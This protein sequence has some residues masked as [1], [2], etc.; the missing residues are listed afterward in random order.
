MERVV[1]IGSSQV[2]MRASALIPRL[3]RYTFG[4]DM[5]ADMNILQKDAAEVVTAQSKGE[6]ANFSLKDLTVF[7][8]VSYIMAMHATELN[9]NEWPT[10]D[11]WLDSFDG[12]MSIYESLPQVLELWALNQKTTSTPR[13]K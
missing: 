4:S 7:E 1:K 13:K 11:E 12:V 9:P 6:E 10:V 5:I 8:N 2:R 3:Y